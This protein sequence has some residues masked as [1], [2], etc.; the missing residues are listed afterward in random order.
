MLRALLLAGLLTAVAAAGVIRVPSQQPTVQQGL[1][2]AQAGDTVLVE[3]GTYRERLV[4][5]SRDGIS[6]VSEQGPEVTTLRP[7]DDSGR[8]LLVPFAEITRATLIRGFTITGGRLVATVTAPGYGAGIRLVYAGPE[9]CHNRIVGNTIECPGGIGTVANAE[10]AGLSVYT[11]VNAP[12]VHDNLIAG[13]EIL[14]DET[15]SGYARGAGACCR[16]P[17]VFYQNEFRENR[18]LTVGTV[19]IPAVSAYGG[20]LCIEGG[21]AVVFCNVFLANRAG[22][23]EL[24]G[25]TASG[26]GLYINDPKGYV[27]HNTFAGNIADQAISW[28]GAICVRDSS[29]TAVKNNIFAGNTATGVYGYGGGICFRGDTSGGLPAWD[30]NDAWDNAPDDYW[31]CRSGPHA[32]SAD[33]RFAA[34]PAGSHYLSATRAGQPYDSPCIDAGDSLL[35]TE[36]L[37]L[38]SLRRTWTTSTDSAYDVCAPDLGYLYPLDRA[39]GLAAEEP[40]PTPRRLSIAP[41]P[42]T[43]GTVRLTGKTGTL[44]PISGPPANGEVS[45]RFPNQARLTLVDA[46]GRTVFSRPQVIEDWSMDISLDLRKVPAGV[47]L[48]RMESG[49]RAT[50]ARLVVLE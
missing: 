46:A 24:P 30:Y 44:P 50:S 6:L 12:L 23:W 8:V 3:P 26:G 16:G 35:M 13:N 21:P 41:N 20:G 31:G 43:G 37:N 33:P 39:T 5:P 17:G 9:I 7:R 10:G 28:G 32:L 2:A 18:S 27:A 4:W 19:P 1:D 25:A 22:S 48:V 42:T 40:L 36:P 15:Q 34:G 38:D 49:G 45:Q 29:S 14:H 47:Y 11:T